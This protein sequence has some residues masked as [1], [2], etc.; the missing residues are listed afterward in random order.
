[1][2][3]HPGLGLLPLAGMLAAFGASPAVEAQT[4]LA[5]ANPETPAQ[6]VL[7]DR[8]VCT[9]VGPQPRTRDLGDP[10]T[11]DCG[12]GRGL[13][14]EVMI[15]GTYMTVDREGY[16]NLDR[17]AIIESE[18]I[19]FLI[20]EIELVDGTVC[21]HAGEGA[22]LAFDG[23]RLNYTCGSLDVALIGDIDIQAGGVYQVEKAYLD[24]TKLEASEM[25]TIARLGA[26]PR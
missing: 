6:I 21:R 24:D 19:R 1:M 5:I 3:K 8:R 17:D 9:Y 15:D 13:R 22:T 10:I 25:M 12:D 26:I 11:Y 4:T 2:M 18:D 23:K 7:P 16:E 20:A 14:G